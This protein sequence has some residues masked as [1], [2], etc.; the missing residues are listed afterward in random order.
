MRL[1]YQQKTTLGGT[2]SADNSKLSLQFTQAHH[3][4]TI[5]DWENVAWFD[6]PRFLL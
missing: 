4:W 2:L 6:R 5:E 3:N 1:E